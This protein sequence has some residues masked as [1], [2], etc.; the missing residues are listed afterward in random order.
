M[1]QCPNCGTATASPDQPFCLVCGAALSAKAEAGARLAPPGPPVGRAEA[2]TAR[3]PA[4][5][6]PGAVLPF[7]IALV[8]WSIYLASPIALYD[9]PAISP[10][11]PGD[12]CDSTEIDEILSLRIMALTDEEKQEARATDPAA[13]RIID[14]T[15]ALTAADM[16]ALHGVMAPASAADG[17][18]PDVPSILVETAFISNPDEE[19]RLKDNAYQEKLAAAILG[20]IKRY[21][22]QNPPLQQRSK[23]AS[24]Y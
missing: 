13:A 5:L 16:A 11:S 19:R 22:A 23:V 9:Y 18:S 20:G 15:D 12:L 21:L 1:G 10:Q 14:R 8:A 3:R 17:G 2:L 4:R 24:T 6:G 7:A